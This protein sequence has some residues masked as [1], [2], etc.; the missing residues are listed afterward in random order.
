[1]AARICGRFILQPSGIDSRNF[2]K[3]HGTK[4]W[5]TRQPPAT[6]AS[7]ARE[8]KILGI[9]MHAEVRWRFCSARTLVRNAGVV[10]CSVA[11]LTSRTTVL[12]HPSE[13]TVGNSENPCPQH[14][15][16]ASAVEAQPRNPSPKPYRLNYV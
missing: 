16:H 10:G 7:S 14:N 13:K 8:A 12:T 3:C 9:S 15:S 11:L 4:N 1:M 6:L 2:R 5:T